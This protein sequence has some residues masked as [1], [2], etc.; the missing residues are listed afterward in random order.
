[1]VCIFIEAQDLNGNDSGTVWNVF[2]LGVFSLGQGD[3]VKVFPVGKGV[4]SE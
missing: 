1:M 2:R 3:T 4:E